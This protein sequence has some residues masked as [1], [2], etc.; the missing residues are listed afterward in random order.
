MFFDLLDARSRS[1][2]KLVMDFPASSLC[3]S[4][5]PRAGDVSARAAGSGP[6]SPRSIQRLTQH[7]AMIELQKI[8]KDHGKSA[9]FSCAL[10][11][12]G[13][14]MV[15]G[16]GDGVLNLYDVSDPA[17][18]QRI[19]GIPHD[20]DAPDHGSAGSVLASDLS[21]DGRM[22]LSTRATTPQH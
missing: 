10:D 15:S 1:G 2:A 12:A 3:H 21:R 14:M 13:R 5:S 4:P 9:V 20:G 18:P 17:A 19:R 16:G 22:V 7:R 11:A 8:L 6:C